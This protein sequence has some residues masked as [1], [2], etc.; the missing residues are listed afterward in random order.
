MKIIQTQN[1]SITGFSGGF[2]G[3]RGPF[4]YISDNKKDASKQ[5][6]YSAEPLEDLNRTAGVMCYGLFFERYLLSM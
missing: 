3:V 6:L 4:G 5:L 1:L 2:P